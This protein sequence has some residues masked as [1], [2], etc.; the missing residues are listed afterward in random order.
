MKHFLLLPLFVLS[1][2]QSTYAQTGP[3]INAISGWW[4]WQQSSGGFAGITFTPASLGH[5]QAMHIWQ[6]SSQVGTDTISIKFLQDDSLVFCG[7]ATVQ[8]DS[9]AFWTP[10]G[11]WTLELLNYF[12]NFFMGN[13]IIDLSTSPVLRLHDYCIDCFSHEFIPGPAIPCVQYVELLPAPF[14]CP[15]D[16]GTTFGVIPGFDNYQ[17]QTLAFGASQ[18]QNLPGATADTLY[19]TSADLGNQYRCLVNGCGCSGTSAPALLDMVL[20]LPPVVMQDGDL[21]FCE[22]DTLN[23]TL[24]APYDTHIQWTNNGV[25]IPGEDSSVLAVTQDGS[26]SVSG[27]PGMCPDFIQPLGVVIDVD[28]TPIDEPLIQ[29]NGLANLDVTNA[30]AFTSFVWYF[31]GSIIQGANSAQYTAT[32]TGFYRVEGFNSSN[33]SRFSQSIYVQFTGIELPGAS[34][35]EVAYDASTNNLFFK[36]DAGIDQ[37]QIF[38]YDGQLLKVLQTPSLQRIKI[39]LGHWTSGLYIYQIQL[40]NGKLHSGKFVR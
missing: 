15:N 21:T 9:S 32:Q 20:F 37:L 36:H 8:Y 26:Y 11:A 16:A 38:S 2:V 6:T 1:F 4:D 22:G 18:W 34:P 19:V 5:D 7:L 10:T 39:P 29:L 23:L 40:S 28:V 35:V 17:W 12:P 13:M 33:C 27:A 30:S 3:I 31:N 24:M 14:L 25:D